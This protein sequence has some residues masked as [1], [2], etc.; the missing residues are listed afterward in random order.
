MTPQKPKLRKREIAFAVAVGV[1]AAGGAS[2]FLFDGANVTEWSG[3][4]D[5]VIA[6]P[7]PVTYD[8]APFDEISTS[9]PQDVIIAFGD[10]L[11]V[12]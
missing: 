4:A 10:T 12:S 6:G 11:S 5:A 3:E 2:L 9:G 1:L 8:V 7:S